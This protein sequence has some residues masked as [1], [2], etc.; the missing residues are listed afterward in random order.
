MKFRFTNQALRRSASRLPLAVLIALSIPFSGQ[1]DLFF[2]DPAGDAQP[3]PADNGDTTVIAPGGTSPTPVVTIL[4]G[5]ILT[6]DPAQTNVLELSGPDQYTVNIAEGGSLAGSSSL[7]LDGKGGIRSQVA[8]GFVLNNNGNVSGGSG[9]A[10][11][12]YLSE[13]IDVQSGAAGT[14]INNNATGTITATTSAAIIFRPTIEAGD[15]GTVN[16]TGVVESF[17]TGNAAGFFGDAILA[18]NNDLTINNNQAVDG[19]GN[20]IA[21]TGIIRGEASGVFAFGPAGGDGLTL[22]NGLGARIIGTTQVGVD[23]QNGA[24]IDNSGL[25]QG[26]LSGI[27]VNDNALIDNSTSGIILG[28]ILAGNNTAINNAGWIGGNGFPGGNAVFLLGGTNTINLNAGS[29]V[30]GDLIGGIDDDTVNMNGGV[31]TAAGLQAAYDGLQDIDFVGAP[32]GEPGFGIDDFLALGTGINGVYGNVLGIETLNKNDDGF[33]FLRGDIHQINVINVNG[34]E[35]YIDSALG[36]SA[37]GGVLPTTIN[38]AAGAEVGGVGTWDSNINL[39][40][41]I[42]AGL[43]PSYLGGLGFDSNVG[44]LEIQGNVNQAD[45]SY[46][47]FDVIPNTGVNN[48]VNSDLIVHNTGIYDV[49]NDSQVVLNPTATNQ[50]ILNGVRTVIDSNVTI[51]GNLPTLTLSLDGVTVLDDRVITLYFSELLFVNDT[52]I[53]DNLV[54]DTLHDFA[55]LPGLTGN[56]VILGA[57]LD[58]FIAAE[59]QDPAFQQFVA[60]LDYSTLG[61]VQNA[62]ASLDPSV[63]LDMASAVVSSSYRLNRVTQNHLAAIRGIG[64]TGG[65]GSGAAGP[66]LSSSG[67]DVSG[68]GTYGKGTVESQA[69]YQSEGS[70]NL[71]GTFSYDWKEFDGSYRGSD[72][73]GQDASFTVGF[74]IPVS[75]NFSLGLLVDGSNGDFD[76]LG[77][78]GDNDSWRVAAYGTVGDS[79]GLYVDFLVGYG[80][81]ELNSNRRLGNIPVALNAISTVNSDSL[82]ALAT[83]GF[84]MESGNLRH[85]PYLGFEYQN[86]NVDGFNQTGGPFPIGV[87]GFEAE[88]TRGLLGYRVDTTSGSFKPYGMV[89]YAHEFEEGGYSTTAFLPNGANFGVSGGVQQSAVLVSIGTGIAISPTLDLN[90]GYQGEIAAGGNGVNSHGVAVGFNYRF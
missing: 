57:A 53:G 12:F 81:H 85:G 77:G 90:V 73:E 5:V 10:G 18:Q 9:V 86:L 47:R 6:G 1:A 34:G 28:G 13:G 44:Q 36:L 15:G 74:D 80:D 4:D 87:A 83:V 33:A 69:V 48:G 70:S 7:V 52:A 62:L 51:Q 82:Q 37:L 23:A 30:N 26:F 32:F 22:T 56:Q 55:G 67:K 19:N 31:T 79:T 2:A 29:F 25:I 3:T 76:Y 58:Q 61:G 14:V 38:V 63:T 84:T 64:G 16:N 46:I 54:L 41:G 24:A 39:L 45:G 89:A 17:W 20:R 8:N 11:L 43:N 42:S 65:T 21:G 50:Y 59:E 68:K 49:G 71:W 27:L 66:V 72:Y 35:L 88:S 75:N 40:G 78:R 60:A